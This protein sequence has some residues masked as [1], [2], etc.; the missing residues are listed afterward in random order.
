MCLPAPSALVYPLMGPALQAQHVP[1]L[2]PADDKISGLMNT[3][4]LEQTIR[5]VD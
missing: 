3:C 1:F 4:F 2:I 5:Q